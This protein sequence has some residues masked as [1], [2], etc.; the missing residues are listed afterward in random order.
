MMA[1]PLPIPTRLDDLLGF[2]QECS[3]G[4]THQV[5]LQRVSLRPDALE[6]VAPLVRE[7]GSGLLVAVVADQ[8]TRV[9][10]GESVYQCLRRDGHRVRLCLIPDGAGGRPHADEDS[11]RQVEASLNDCDVAVA[12]GSGTLNDLVKLA[13]FRQ[14]HPYLVVATAPSM[15]GYT[16]AIAAIMVQG[17]KRTVECHQP[18]A[19][20]ADLKV[21]VE[22]PHELIAAGLGDLE[23]KPTATADFRLGGC[24]RKEYYCP[25][26]EKVVLAAEARVAEAAKEI[27]Q[28]DPAAI[29]LLTE[30]LLLSG[31]SMKLAGSS[32]P[33]SGGEHLISHF[34]DSTAGAEGRVEGWHGAQVGVATLVSAALY[35]ELQL[36]DPS[37]L[38]L[39][40]LIRS[41]LSQEEC[42]RQI[43]LH[44]GTLADEVTAEYFKKHLGPEALRKELETITQQWPDV[45]RE[46]NPVLRPSARIRSILQAG[47]APTT[48]TGLGLTSNHLRQGYLWA[49]E[50]RGRFTALDWAA[51]MGMLE[52]LL[53]P[54]WKRCGCDA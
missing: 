38:D 13:S 4:R 40:E 37:R 41:H 22:A 20:I 1:V 51:E 8:R 54:V 7:I 33:A 50:I 32:S 36:V 48:I 35:E 21:L 15:N 23:S 53:G 24:L 9:I 42:T 28:G 31:I 47:R 30:A 3:C 43:R 46:L 6:D 45:W 27:G 49:R 52:T 11:C 10:A 34:W 12:V 39:E 26:P 2:A 25:A 17:L 5:D 18:Y 16:S 29:A 19:V 14:H 44:H